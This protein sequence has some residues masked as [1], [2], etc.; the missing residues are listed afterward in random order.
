MMR[1]PENI[2]AAPRP[3]TARPTI[4]AVELGETPQMRDP[5]SKIAMPVRKTHLML[6]KV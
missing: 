5:I 2:P 4:K 6:K 3:A 1:A